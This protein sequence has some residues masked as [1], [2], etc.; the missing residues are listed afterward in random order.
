MTE[1][2]KKLIKAPGLSGREDGIA[3]TAGELIAP[4]VD[5]VRRDSL[6][7]VIAYKKGTGKNKKKIMFAA[8]MDEIGFLVTFIE[9]KGFIRFAPIG[10][11]SAL[12]CAYSN[13]VFESGIPGVMVPDAS[14]EPSEVKADKL[15]VDIGAKSRKEAEKKVKIGD[16]LMVAPSFTRLMGR[17]IAGR[18]LDDR[19]GC[20]VMIETAKRLGKI[21]DDIYFVFTAQEEVGCRGA[22]TAAFA[23]APDYAIAFD[24]TG[25]G[26]ALGAKPMAVSLGGGAA[27]KVKD[28]SVICDSGVVELLT[29]LAEKNKIKYQKEVLLRGGTDTSSMQLSG[30]GCRAGAISIPTRYIHSGVETLDLGDVQACIDLAAEFAKADK[31]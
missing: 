8:H 21:K 15:V 1:L 28:S 4:Y 24:V 7:N 31:E 27:I 3:K 23:V 19:I 12:A 10:G 18:P 13:V 22:K 29:A 20:A 25:T 9:E 11:I 26:D 14:V 30:A 5:E 16:Y 6:G 2:I 17:R